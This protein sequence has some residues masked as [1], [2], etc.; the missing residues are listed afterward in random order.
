MTG[1]LLIAVAIV[2]LIAV[3]AATRWVVRRVNSLAMK[4]VSCLVLFPVLLVLPVADELVGKQQFDSLCTKYAVQVIDEQNAPNSRVKSVGGSGDWY[5]AGTAVRIRIQPWIYQD[6]TTQN[7]VASYHT[8]HAEGGWLIRALG[9]SET[10][11][12]LLFSRSCAPPDERSFLKKFNI[13][14][15]N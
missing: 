11:S 6:I 4:V 2:W 5:A 13:D 8:L 1:I 7:V 15:A 14:I 3:L 9:I 10:R 12:P